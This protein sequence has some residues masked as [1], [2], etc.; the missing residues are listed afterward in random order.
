MDRLPSSGHRICVSHV[1]VHESLSASE[2]TNQVEK[3]TRSV[4]VSQASSR[5]LQSISTKCPLSKDGGYS[6]GLRTRVSFFH[7]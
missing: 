1:N 3:V 4:N 2:E 7:G 6:H 5:D